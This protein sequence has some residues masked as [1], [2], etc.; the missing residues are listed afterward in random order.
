M[1]TAPSNFKAGFSLFKTLILI[2]ILY[3][4]WNYY[5]DN[6]KYKDSPKYVVEFK[7]ALKEFTGQND[8]VK[9][10]YKD[11]ISAQVEAK[12]IKY[13]FKNEKTKVFIAK[14][15][16]AENEVT[17]LRETYSNYKDETENF[18]DGLD[19]K[20]DQIQNDNALK[21]KMKKFSKK[22]ALKM[23]KSIV[24]MDQN[25]EKLENSIIKGNNLII[26]LETV[27]S[28]NELSQDIKDFDILLDSSSDIFT[29]LDSLIIE[30]TSVLDSE[31][32]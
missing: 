6:Y 26:A 31:L 19:D 1:N 13:V 4:A 29:E 18:L 5:E 23:A 16:T 3:Y 15:K 32:K 25:L 28:F 11:A 12:K 14:W 17:T 30:G 27:S 24:K 8:T 9:N 7:N 2:I 22:R 20:L 21:S 10:A